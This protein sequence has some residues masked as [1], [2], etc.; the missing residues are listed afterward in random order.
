MSADAPDG[1]MQQEKPVF[2]RIRKDNVPQERKRND[3]FSQQQTHGYQGQRDLFRLQNP[4][5][6]QRF[7]H[8]DKAPR[9]T[10]GDAR[11]TPLFRPPRTATNEVWRNCWTGGGVDATIHT[12]DGPVVSAQNNHLEEGQGA[13]EKGR[14]VNARG[15]SSATR[16]H[17]SDNGHMEV[18]RD[19]LARAQR[20]CQSQ[21]RRDGPACRLS[22]QPTGGLAG[23]AARGRGHCQPNSA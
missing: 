7:G 21:Q 5:T 23:A 20:S 22:E 17:A 9:S 19:L 16:D 10:P 6:C 2:E 12:R 3:A 8:L 1:M 13:A 14:N 4:W 18:V 11:V 15:R